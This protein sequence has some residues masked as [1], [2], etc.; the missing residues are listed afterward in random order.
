MKNKEL[1]LETHPLVTPNHLRRKAAIYIRQSSEEQVRENTGSTDFQR[2]LVAVAQRYGWPESLIETIDEDLGRSGSSSERR[3]GW[4]RLKQMVAAKEVGVVIVATISRLSRQVLDFEVFRLTAAA[5]NTL[6]YTDGRFV[7]PADS[8]D[9]IF[10]QLTAMLASYENRQRVK[11]MSQARMTKAKQGAVVSALPVGWIKGPDQSYDY[12][13]ET[14]DTI[15]MIIDKFWET[16]SIRRTVKALAKAGVQIPSRRG[17]RLYFTKPTL[18]RVTRILTNPA[19][20]GTYAFGKTQCQPGGPVLANGQSKR[21]KVPEACWTQTF[22]H[23]PAYMTR[24]EQEEIKSILNG[25]R[26][27]R[28]DRAGRGPAL[29]Q[30]L[31]RCAVCGETLVVSYHRRSYS[32]G[33]GWKLLKYAETPC[34]RF[35]SR[36]FDQYILGEVFKVLRTPPVD[37]LRS[38]LEV[39]RSQEQARLSWI[40]AERERLEHEERKAQELVDRSYGRHPRVYDHAVEKLE[41]LLQE[42]QQFEQK[43]AIERA[44]PKKLETREELEELCR[45]ASDVPSL[46]HHPVVTHQE[47]KELLRCLIDHI[48]VAATKERIDATIF[49]KSGGQTPIRIWRDIGRYNLIRELHAQKLTV[50]EIKEHLAAGKTSTGQKVN[51]CLGRLYGVLRKLG[52]KPNRFSAEYLWLRDNA[53]ALNRQGQSVD[54]ITEHFNKQGFKSPSGKPWTRDM[55]YGL[56]RAQGKTPILLEEVH[57]EVIT[58]ARA[59]GLNYQEMAVEFN[60]REIRRRDG[61]PWTARD[62]KKRWGDLNRLQRNRAQKGLGRTELS[63]PVVQ[64]RSA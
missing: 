4:Q 42:K 58:E 5:N 6:L 60:E 53:L 26:F 62:I 25:N 56:L 28:R 44:T 54:C 22:N 16:R 17:Q 59:R 48:V 1:T 37:M 32:Y 33:C 55:V 36:E 27:Q 3:T 45:L 34:T 2:S 9:I 51:I 21:T 38:A 30:G 64:Q 19:Y 14:K 61:Q 7:D 8:N 10:S 41:E 12:D 47:R 18:G 35:E 39:S 31:L 40:E 23:H 20:A 50:F 49:W 46:W 63:E 57:R 13:P 52:L 43:I 11:L 15:R 24:E 29:T